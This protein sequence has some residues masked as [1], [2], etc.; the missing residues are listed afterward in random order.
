M[1]GKQ[2]DSIHSGQVNHELEQ[3]VH[4]MELIIESGY[5]GAPDCQRDSKVSYPF[6]ILQDKFVGDTGKLAMYHR[7]DVL[8]VIED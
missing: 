5:D 8:D 6:S 7:V 1:V 3:S 4:V 2:V